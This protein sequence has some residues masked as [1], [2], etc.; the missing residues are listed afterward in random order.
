[1]RNMILY[2]R[3]M[4]LVVLILIGV[5]LGQIIY[6]TYNT[7][8]YLNRGQIQLEVPQET[9][10]APLQTITEIKEERVIL[11]WTDVPARK[12]E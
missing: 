1:M 11:D 8:Q 4:V 2:I 6:I 7:T 3:I 5:F 9:L 12:T 10:Q